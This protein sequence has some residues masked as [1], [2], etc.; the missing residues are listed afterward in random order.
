LL[1]LLVNNYRW[2]I[3]IPATIN[4]VAELSEEISMDKLP[5]EN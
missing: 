5:S 4:I 1:N 2:R 3:T